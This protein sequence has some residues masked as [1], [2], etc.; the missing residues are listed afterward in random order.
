MGKWSSQRHGKTAPQFGVLSPMPGDEVNVESVT[1]HS[2]DLSYSGT[3]PAPADGWNWAAQTAA[4]AVLIQGTP[5]SSTD[6]NIT[7]LAAGTTY[8]VLLAFYKGTQRLSEWN[9]VA[10]VPTDP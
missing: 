9:Y 6:I 10:D 2:I 7:G 3:F 8:R 4:G 5:T 1:D